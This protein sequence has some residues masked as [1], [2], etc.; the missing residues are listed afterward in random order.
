MSVAQKANKLLPQVISMNNQ[1]SKDLTTKFKASNIFSELDKKASDS[2]MQIVKESEKRAHRIKSGNL[3]QSI[4]FNSIQHYTEKSTGIINDPH[5]STLIPLTEAENKLKNHST[6]MPIKNSLKILN[7]L[8]LQNEP[9]FISDKNIKEVIKK[10]DDYRYNLSPEIIKKNNQIVTNLIEE[11]NQAL[12]FH[13]K[14]YMNK[15]KSLKEKDRDLVK[16]RLNSIKIPLNIKML[17]YSKPKVSFP[18]AD[19]I[20]S[21]QDI[22]K[23]LFDLKDLFK[24]TK[25][26]IQAEKISLMKKSKGN[27]MSAISEYKDKQ[28]IPILGTTKRN[29]LSDK[30]YTNTALL[31]LKEAFKN[32]SI[33]EM[34]EHKKNTLEVLIDFDLPKFGH[35]DSNNNHIL[36]LIIFR[37]NKA[38]DNQ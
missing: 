25:R 10:E 34:F 23:E 21:Q 13:L 30:T 35:Y 7:D 33:N 11:D 27:N 19:S 1:I 2:F 22:N 14:N 28:K 15:I 9:I 4:I 37:T 32:Y 38:K 20:K 5:Y 16:S 3:L 6:Q 8:K 12:N 26:G 29:I 36:T 31:V 18:K 17:C 24:L